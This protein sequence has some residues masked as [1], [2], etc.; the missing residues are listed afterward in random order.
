MSWVR[1]FDHLREVS[2]PLVEEQRGNQVTATAGVDPFDAD[3]FWRGSGE[4]VIGAGDVVLLYSN[5]NA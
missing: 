5:N 3:L 2:R 4:G 1:R